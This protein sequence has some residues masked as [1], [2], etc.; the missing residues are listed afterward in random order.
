MQNRGDLRRAEPATRVRPWRS[1]AS[2][3]DKGHAR[4]IGWTDPRCW[5]GNPAARN[6]VPARRVAG[7]ARRPKE[8]TRNDPGCLFAGF[9]CQLALVPSNWPR[10]FSGPNEGAALKASL[11]AKPPTAARRARPVSSPVLAGSGTPASISR[12]YRSARAEDAR[13]AKEK[14]SRVTTRAVTN[15]VT[16]RWRE[17]DSNPRSP[18]EEPPFET[19]CIPKPR[20]EGDGVFRRLGAP[21]PAKC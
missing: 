5:F 6:V 10:F 9:P 18:S 7:K 3:Q 12:S 11:T 17:T 15:D 2:R 20:K 8:P 1:R 21:G 13:G 16:G 19:T 4:P 14:S